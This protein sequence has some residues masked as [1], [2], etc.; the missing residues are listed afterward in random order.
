[1]VKFVYTSPIGELG[2]VEENGALV[3][4]KFLWEEKKKEE[5]QKVE[6][7]YKELKYSLVLKETVKQL[8]EYFQGKRREFDLPLHP[9]G[10]KFQQ[11]VWEALRTIPYGEVKTYKDVAI[12]IGNEKACRAVG[13]ANNKNPI[14]IIIPCH[15]VI[16]SSK[17]LV[18][19]AGGL[20]T[21]I[22]LL[23]IEGYSDFKK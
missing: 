19:Y 3:E 4:I 16:G 7:D 11:K 22:S 23:H 21:K 14:P 20:S 6:G 9:H 10:T 18:G 5:F 13:L 2:L 17:K 15:R 8:E 1:M 12:S